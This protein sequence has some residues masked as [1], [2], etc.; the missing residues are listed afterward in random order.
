MSELILGQV[1]PQGSNQDG[2]EGPFRL[3]KMADQIVS[4]LHGKY[5]EQA[6]RG[7]MFAVANQAA[8]TTT[9]ALA[10]TW[11][12]LGISNPVGS[13]VN[14]VILRFTCSQFAVGAAAA[15]GLMTGS[16]QTAGSLTPRN[17]VVGGVAAKATASAG[18]TIATPVL[19]EVYGSV[20]SLATTGY[21]LQNGIQ[22]DIAGSLIVPPGFFV[23]SYTT[24]V[25][26]TALIFGLLWEE[27]P[28]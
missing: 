15:V 10:T 3:G 13:G 25:T 23:A 21:G 27:V 9:A 18:A 28:V 12:G 20:G 6:Y 22:A 4:E 16:G 26:T 1:G 7:N 14:L 5:Y 24:I 2:Y 17:R 19:E 8:V 11:T